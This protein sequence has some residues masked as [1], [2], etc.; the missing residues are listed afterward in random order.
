[1]VGFSKDDFHAC[2]GGRRVVFVGDSTIRQIYWA[3]AA[4]LD[5]LKAHVA[6]LDAIVEDTKHHDLR[7]E[8]EGVDLYFVWDPWLNS[9]S[10]S[11]EL[12]KF[13][14]HETFV[15]AGRV[16]PKEDVSAALIIAGSPGLWAARHGGDDY[17]D[18]FTRGINDI[19]VHLGSNMD[20]TMMYPSA[21]LRRNFDAAPNHILVAPVQV[22]R[23]DSLSPGR[24]D[25]ITPTTVDRMND[26]LTKLPKDEQ[27]HV[28]WSYNK[29]TQNQW[30]AF[31]DTGLHVVDGVAERKVD[32]AL[33][34]HC[35]APAIGHEHPYQRTCCT[36]YPSK[37]VFQRTLIFM[38]LVGYPVLL[39]AHR[40]T[41]ITRSLLPSDEVLRGMRSMVFAVVWCWFSDRTHLFVKVE[42]HYYQN[43]FMASCAVFWLVSVLSI[44]RSKHNLKTSTSPALATKWSVPT[45]EGNQGFLS[46]DQSDEWKGWMQALIL[47]YHYNYA[48]QTLW[49]YKII[50]LLVSAYVFLSAYGHTMHLLKTE[51]FSLR[52][53]ASVIFRL[54]LLSALLPYMVTT[55]YNFYYFAPVITFWYLVVWATLRSFRRYNQDPL[56]LLAK[57]LVATT[58]TTYM[59]L[60]PQ[61][62][63]LLSTICRGVFRMPWDS[64]E[65][66]FRLSL[67]CYIV[68]FGMMTASVAHRIAL[69]RNRQVLPDSSQPIAP[70]TYRPSLIDP[71]LSVIAFPDHLTEPLKPVTYTFCMVFILFFFV[72]TQKAINDKEQ[73]NIGHPFMSWI[74]ILSSILLRNSSQALRNRYLALPAALGKISLETYILQYHIWLAGDATGQLSTGLWDRYGSPFRGTWLAGPGKALEMVLLTVVFL[75]LSAQTRR[76]TESLTNWLFGKQRTVKEV[77]VRA[78]LV[79]LTFWLCNLMY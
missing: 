42:R 21:D 30:N 58:L 32:I 14:I 46:R 25:T 73:Y 18:I 17:L 35:N 2:L 75:C 76:A 29:M 41:R 5:P 7:F 61:P 39:W 77:R 55:D 48:S 68:S 70:R 19:K 72:V 52:R 60:V 34:A 4:R 28:M 56:L 74:P 11:N 27:S 13:R 63:E 22:P 57:V 23:Y 69:I 6:V 33:N 51:D 12:T 66:R 3:A 67:E 20:S 71:A 54:N 64:A 44:R 8:S 78:V 36:R 31:E 62:L 26:Y 37:P 24:A 53:V 43:T 10:L 65:A 49:I 16:K 79:L 9:S 38:G 40:Y 1:M 45:E 15:V 47:I 59:I 50:R